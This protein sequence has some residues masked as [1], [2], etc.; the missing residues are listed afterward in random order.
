MK[1]LLGPP[2]VSDQLGGTDFKKI[3]QIDG[4]SKSWR[5]NLGGLGGGDFSHFGGDRLKICPSNLLG[6]KI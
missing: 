1:L 6:A 3:L 5:G 2:Q 4:F